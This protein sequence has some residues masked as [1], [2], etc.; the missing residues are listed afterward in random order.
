MPGEG[1][2]VPT[3]E[4]TMHWNAP[5]ASAALLAIVAT[6]GL[7]QEPDAREENPERDGVPRPGGSCQTR[8]VCAEPRRGC[9]DAG[10]CRGKPITLHMRAHKQQNPPALHNPAS[11]HD[12]PRSRGL[13]RSNPCP[14]SPPT[15][16]APRP[17]RPPA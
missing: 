14:P 8:R 1:T 4:N 9:R 15:R 13:D 11:L 17:A 7:A 16:P 10:L 12:L 6:A 2:A 3:K 5:T